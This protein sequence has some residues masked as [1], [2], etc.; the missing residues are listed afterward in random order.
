M[1]EAAEVTNPDSDELEDPSESE[2]DSE[3]EVVVGSKQTALANSW[4]SKA[5]SAA[6]NLSRPLTALL[7]ATE[8]ANRG[9]RMSAT[10][11]RI[12]DVVGF[13]GEIVWDISKPNGTPRKVLNV[14]LF[15]VC[16]SDYFRNPN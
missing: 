4:L 16:L 14:N 6:S 15:P 1:F 8:I 7:A 2:E 5:T 13:K 3:R 10:I 12:A 11:W 9:C